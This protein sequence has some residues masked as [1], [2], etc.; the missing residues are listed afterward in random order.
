MDVGASRT[1]LEAVREAVALGVPLEFALATVTRNPATQLRLHR[2]GRVEVGAD[3]DLVRLDAAL[4]VR[5]CFAGGVRMVKAGRAVR[6][7][8]FEA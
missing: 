5:D 2:K 1:L 3:A 6:R 7:G 4:A 8:L